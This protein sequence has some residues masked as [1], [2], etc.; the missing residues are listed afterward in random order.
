MDDG[1]PNIIKNKSFELAIT[2]V[3]VYRFYRKKRRNLCLASNCCVPEHPLVQM[4]E[5]L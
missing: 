4:S 1:K 2:I 5:K 3:G